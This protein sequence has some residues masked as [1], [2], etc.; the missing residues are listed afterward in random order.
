MRK[1]PAPNE[2]AF[3]KLGHAFG[4]DRFFK[5]PTAAE[6]FFFDDAHGGRDADVNQVRAARKRTSANLGNAFGKD[7]FLQSAL[8]H[9]CLFA[10]NAYV[11]GHHNAFVFVV[12]AFV[13]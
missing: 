8:V 11:F 13:K 3:G 5:A 9:E 12:N 10:D 7:D 4:D 6:H 2:N 1:A